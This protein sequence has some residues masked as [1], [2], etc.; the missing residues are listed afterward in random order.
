M[1]AGLGSRST[2][3]KAKRAVRQMAQELSPRC[4]V[5]NLCQA[6]RRCE[7]MSAQQPRRALCAIV[8]MRLQR[9]R[10]KSRQTRRRWNEAGGVVVRWVRG[11][12]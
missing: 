5:A 12:C 4:G 10:S 7:E 2:T 6:L 11:Q 8:G 1:A 3:C 9:W